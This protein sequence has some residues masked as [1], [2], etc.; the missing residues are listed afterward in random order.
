MAGIQLSGLAS[1]L[2]TASIID[3]L[4]AVERQP[5][6]RI[7]MRQASEQARR[8]GLNQVTTQLKALQDAATALRSTGTWAD[9]QSVTSND[10]TKVA[11][12]RTGGA[13]PGGYD[14]AV[15]RLASSTQRTY[16]YAPPAAGTNLT[17]T[18]KDAQ[19][20]N[21]PTTIPLAAGASLDDAVSTI[22]T[23][24]GSPVYAVNVAGKLVLASRATGENAR[25][26]MA[27]S[28]GGT[29]TQESER[30]GQK[31]LINVDGV[32]YDSETNTVTGAIPGVS[33]TLKGLTDSVQ[34]DVGAPG[35]DQSAL[36]DKVKAFTSAYNTVVDS[37]RAKVNEKP[38]ANA[39]TASQAKTGALYGDAGLNTILRQLRQAVSDPIAGNATALD[40][41]AELGVS[42]GAASSA[43]NADSVAGKLTFDSAKLTAALSADPLAV[44]KLLGGITGTNGFAQ[45][46]QG[47][48]DPVSGTNGVLTQRISSEDSTLSSI[49]NDLIRFDKR[50]TAKQDALSKQWSALE[51]ALQKAQSRASDIS[52]LISSSS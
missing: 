19:G 8:D 49:A 46:I 39:A 17:F 29:L 40:E 47:I 52:G 3:S 22:N 5:R 20:A 30:L 50:M 14:I 33:L 23:T 36:A 2:D 26:T 24:A 1:G 12:T 15:T 10:P 6:T 51:T 18:V 45:R 35:P 44:R 4:M 13:G 28:A 16:T 27:D 48:L 21:V 34:V 43:I 11:V 7:E 37:I 42:T 9:T 41:M 25:F 31:A 32:D 38:V